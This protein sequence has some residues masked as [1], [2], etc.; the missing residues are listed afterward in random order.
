M[1]LCVFG[2]V[3]MYLN[4]G[5]RATRKSQIIGLIT[6]VNRLLISFQTHIHACLYYFC[7]RLRFF[8]L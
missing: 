4:P 8:I 5:A 2:H 1:L 7:S 6:F 3:S